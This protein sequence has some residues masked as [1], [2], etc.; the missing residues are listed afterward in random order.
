MVSQVTGIQNDGRAR[1]SPA[2]LEQFVDRIRTVPANRAPPAAAEAGPA[3]INPGPPAA[4]GGRG[5]RR[6]SWAQGA[7]GPPTRER[8]FPPRTSAVAF[9]LQECSCRFNVLATPPGSWGPPVLAAV[10]HCDQL[11][12]VVANG[13]YGAPLGFPGAPRGGPKSQPPTRTT[14]PG[15]AGHKPATRRSGGGREHPRWRQGHNRAWGPRPDILTA[16]PK[17]GAKGPNIETGRPRARPHL[18][19]RA[20]QI[21]SRRHPAGGV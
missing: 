16:N 14:P 4:S 17:I 21:V 13:P 7:P 6:R 1:P 18:G 20:G 10:G 11:G 3:D 2:G 15:G 9:G 19:I 5:R 12:T 8:S